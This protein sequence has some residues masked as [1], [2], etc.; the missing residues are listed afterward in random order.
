MAR[1]SFWGALILVV[2]PVF[3]QQAAP[4][5]VN[6]LVAG[7][8]IYVAPMPDNL[9][10]WISDFLQRWGKYKVTGN[11]EGVDL[12]LQAVNP[13]DKETE[14]EKRGGVVQPKGQ[15]SRLPAPIPR[16]ERKEVPVVSIDVIN[17]VTSERIWHA[18][19][20]NR[21]QKKDEPDPPAGPETT[22]FAGGMTA[23]QIAMKVTRILQAY[24]AEL[25]KSGGGEKK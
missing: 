22:I 8:V 3:G 16:R 18:E 14:W 15:G 4:K 21:K 7:K 10:Q 25:E 24:V 2:A 6:E 5:K 20:L 11:P 9:D 23:D 13:G 19:V 1:L 17:W 12:V